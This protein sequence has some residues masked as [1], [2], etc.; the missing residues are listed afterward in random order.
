MFA[1]VRITLLLKTPFS[2]FR[3][4][5]K[6]MKIRIHFIDLI[7]EYLE[8][9][10]VRIFFN[11][12]FSC[13]IFGSL[14]DWPWTNLK[15]KSFN[16]IVYRKCKHISMQIRQPNSIDFFVHRRKP[17]INFNLFM[18]LQFTVGR[19]T[20][21]MAF[22]CDLSLIV[23]SQC[24]L[25]N[26]TP[27]QILVGLESNRCAHVSTKKVRIFQFKSIFFVIENW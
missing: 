5:E 2:V 14:I 15:K 23:L 18:Y 3:Q 19:H 11:F 26:F 7:R 9:D 25:Q 4:W 12:S 17:K 21:E 16:Q 13:V 22:V 8:L 1:W 10:V 6:L 24:Q 27:I 20:C